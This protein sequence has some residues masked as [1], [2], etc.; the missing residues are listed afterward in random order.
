[1]QALFLA[2]G[3]A[4]VQLHRGP[5]SSAGKPARRG[6]TLGAAPGINWQQL[7]VSLPPSFFPSSFPLS[8]LLPPLSVTRFFSCLFCPLVNRIPASLSLLQQSN[9]P[10]TRF[11]WQSWRAQTQ[12]QMVTLPEFSQLTVLSC[13]PFVSVSHQDVRMVAFSRCFSS[14]FLL[15]SPPK[16]KPFCFYSPSIRKAVCLD[17]MVLNQACVQYI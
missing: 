15:Y 13:L 12:T 14:L 2:S 4:V 16:M 10:G 7:I 6:A 5:D 3:A 8:S 1:M 17:V 11:P 9:E